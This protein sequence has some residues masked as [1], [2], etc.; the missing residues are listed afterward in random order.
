MTLIIKMLLIRTY[1]RSRNSL[2][3]INRE[4]NKDMKKHLKKLYN[5]AKRASLIKIGLLIAS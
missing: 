1:V 5:I 4:I 2:P 3:W